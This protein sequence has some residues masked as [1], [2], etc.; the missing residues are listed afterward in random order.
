[1]NPMYVSMQ[2]LYYYEQFQSSKFGAEQPRPKCE[3]LYD[4]F[5]N[6]RDDEGEHVKTIKACQDG[7]I[8]QDLIRKYAPYL[9]SGFF[10]P[11]KRLFV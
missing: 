5:S 2:D 11:P 3:S 4:V 7:Q 1:M 8:I 10:L 9:V 6:I